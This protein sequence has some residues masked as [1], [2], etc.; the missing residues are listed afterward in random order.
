MDRDDLSPSAPATEDS[1]SPSSPPRKRPGRWLRIFGIVFVLVVIVAIISFFVSRHS[2]HKAIAAALPQIDGAITVAGLHAP[3]TIQRDAQ[4]VPH[5]RAS[6]MDDL[7][8]AQGFVTA[9]DRLWQ[10][11]LLRRHAAGELAAILG[12][13]MLAHDRLQRTLQV[14]AAAD[15]AIAALP[16]D[17]KHWLDD[18][19]HGVNASIA[20]QRAHLPLEFVLL[21]YQPAY[22]TPRDSILIELSM[23]QDLT[24]SFPEKL[25]REAL[26]AHLTPA[27]MADLYPVGS[28][29]DHPP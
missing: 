24:T 11:D 2:V 20:L 27:L 10:M 23:D 1:A 14:R 28:W 22:W 19:A 16:A 17:Q 4:G 15:R 29:R 25:G 21:H 5:I 18:Y 9:Q 6:S 13:S 8:F 7:I 26:A 12:P 3:V